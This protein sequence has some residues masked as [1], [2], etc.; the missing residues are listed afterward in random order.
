M[1]TTERK[2]KN[3]IE[4]QQI[5][6]EMEVEHLRMLHDTYDSDWKRGD[7]PHG[8]MIFTDE[9]SSEAKRDRDFAA[10][11]DELKATLVEFDK[12]LKKDIGGHKR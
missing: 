11:I 7:E 5:V 8:V 6:D 1:A 12:R 4:R 2:Y 10:E 9:P 3:W